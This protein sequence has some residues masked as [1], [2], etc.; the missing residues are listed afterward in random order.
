MFRTDHYWNFTKRNFL[1]SITL[2]QIW[3][4]LA[5]TISSQLSFFNMKIHLGFY[6][7]SKISNPCLMRFNRIKFSCTTIF[8]I[9]F[10]SC[11]NIP[12]NSLIATFLFFCARNVLSFNFN[13][14]WLVFTNTVVDSVLNKL[15]KWLNLLVYY[16]ILIKKRIN[17]FPL[18]SF[19]NLIFSSFSKSSRDCLSC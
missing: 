14:I 19:L 13:L 4:I 15:I 16:T 7:I 2:N 9:W 5:S 18:I 12:K 6:T 1:F 17:N 8:Q 10:L 3:F 11:I